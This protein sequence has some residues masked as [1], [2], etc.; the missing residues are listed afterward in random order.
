MD[1]RPPH[2]QKVQLLPPRFRLVRTLAHQEGRNVIPPEVSLPGPFATVPRG[3]A[4][5]AYPSFGEF[6]Q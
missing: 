3:A 2:G 4:L 6:E 1:T 5:A